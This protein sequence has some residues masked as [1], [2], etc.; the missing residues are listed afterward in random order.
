MDLSSLD[1][2][3][4]VADE[5]SVTRA[6]DRLQRAQSNVTTRLRQLEEQLGTALFL[7]EGKRMTLTP[8]GQL[9]QTYAQRLLALAAEAKAA[10]QPQNPKGRLRVGT[11]ESTAASRLPGL[12]ARY[13]KRWPEVA[14]EL[15]MA[16]SASLI[17]QLLGHQLDCALVADTAVLGVALDDSLEA[18]AVFQE[19]L[20]LLLPAE[21]PEVDCAG[22]LQ[23]SSLAALEPGCTYRRMA[24][25]WLAGKPGMRVLE[26]GSYHAIFACVA[27]GT[28][29]GVA[30]RSVLELQRKPPGLRTQPLAQVDTLL[31]HRRG[32]VSA[33]F[34]A[35]QGMLLER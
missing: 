19:E 5:L 16:P 8:E 4:V 10:L 9:F 34:E 13:H 35:L 31:L 17:E 32:Y 2:F 7:R 25:Q 28:S 23:V 15:Q 26:L 33:A 18:R 21:H 3:C 24:Q 27:A 30:P 12:L 6:A 1:I 14:L 22:Q 20:L 29:V 11:M